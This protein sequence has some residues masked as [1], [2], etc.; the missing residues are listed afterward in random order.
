M[1]PC[2]SQS[3]RHLFTKSVQKRLFDYLAEPATFRNSFRAF[4]G[5]ELDPPD[6]GG[7]GGGKGVCVSPVTQG[8]G[9][10]VRE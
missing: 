3:K 6:P 8:K 4:R 7:A 1:C 5:S 10:G 9:G 2:M